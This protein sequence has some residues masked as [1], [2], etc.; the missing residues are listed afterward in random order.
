MS[1]AAESVVSEK[2]TGLED[3]TRSLRALLRTTRGLGVA[4]TEVVERELA[5]AI[6]IS[7]QLRDKVVSPEALR[8]ARHHGLIASFRNDAHHAVDLA[9]DAGGVLFNS[10][11]GFLENFADQRRPPLRSSKAV[12]STAVD[13]ND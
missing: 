8:E 6:S 5:M 1:E 12:H 10:V 2:S 3:V 4:T 11:L 9:A 7:E 13:K